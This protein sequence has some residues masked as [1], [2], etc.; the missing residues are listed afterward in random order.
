MFERGV[1]IVY[2]SG[3][4]A[5]TALKIRNALAEADINVSVYA[6]KRYAREGVTPVKDGLKEFIGEVFHKF[7]G[8]VAVMATGIIVRAVGPLLKSKLSDPAIVCVDA[9]GRFAISLVSG[10]YRGAN[11]L[12]ELIANNIGATAVITTAS[13]ALGKKSVE[14][15][16]KHLHCRI[17]N[18][19]K[20]TA[21]NALIVNDGKI[22]LTFLGLKLFSR[23][24]FGFKAEAVKELSEALKLLEAFDGGIIVSKDSVRVEG[25]PKPVVVLKPKTIAL[26]VG[27]RKEIS[28]EG[29]LRAVRLALKRAR[30]PLNF[31]DKM[32][33]VDV[34]RESSGIVGAAERLG[35]PLQFFSLERLRG[36]SH[37]D[38][39]PDSEIVK[40]KL[41]VGGVC[42]RAALL[43][44]GGK[45]RLILKKVKMEGVTVAIAEEE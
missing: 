36:L 38:L 19:E 45:A 35:L 39:S 14:E 13:E 27:A 34:K 4:A 43:A 17:A 29:V 23:R 44:L 11:F 21:V 7:D 42:E 32:A 24:V 37:E 5:E 33:T 1:A 18:P 40:E 9:A 22:L 2:A 41:G 10:H 26:G 28:E 16:A 6:L 3:K 12:A 25:F 8:I 15:I 20:L 30:I 31:V